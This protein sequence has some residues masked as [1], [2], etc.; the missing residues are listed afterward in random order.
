MIMRGANKIRGTRLLAVIAMALGLSPAWTHAGFTT[1]LDTDAGAVASYLAATTEMTIPGKTGDAISSVTGPDLTISFT[2][3]LAGVQ[4]A[5]WGNWATPTTPDVLWT[6]LFATSVT[7]DLSAS[8]TVT[9]FG[10][11]AEPRTFDLHDIRAEF[12]NG[13]TSLGSIT[14][15][16]DGDGGSRLLAAT[17]DNF[18]ADL[19]NTDKFTRVVISSDIDFAFGRIRYAATSNQVP[20]P[21]TI[22]MLIGAAGVAIPVFAR[23]RRANRQS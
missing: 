13:A 20:E 8:S 12:F 14:L 1:I 5:D 16:I 15:K 18:G 11:E 4:S 22:V 10:F 7:L 21:G 2:S 9:T 6:S 19:G 23:R 3:T 17:L